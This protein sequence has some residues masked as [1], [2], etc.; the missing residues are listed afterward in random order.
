MIEATT[1]LTRAVRQRI[2]VYSCEINALAKHQHNEP[3]SVSVRIH[4]PPDFTERISN[5]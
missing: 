3:A 4:H 2:L 1:T 5:Q